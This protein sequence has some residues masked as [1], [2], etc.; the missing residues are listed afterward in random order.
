MSE[1][2]AAF[3]VLEGAGQSDGHGVSARA[4]PSTGGQR[5]VLFLE[6]LVK[7]DTFLV[8]PIHPA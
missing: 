4:T 3:W 8:I 1:V 6:Q 2:R 5:R 7:S